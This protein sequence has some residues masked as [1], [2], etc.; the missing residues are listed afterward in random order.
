MG[1]GVERCGCGRRCGRSVGGTGEVW[2]L[3][4]GMEA[5]GMSYCQQNVFRMVK[6]TRGEVKGSKRAWEVCR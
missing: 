6:V 2:R 4:G 5:R 3:V 1:G